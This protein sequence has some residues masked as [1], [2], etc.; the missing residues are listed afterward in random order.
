MTTALGRRYETRII[1]GRIRDLVAHAAFNGL[2]ANERV[3]G[4][5]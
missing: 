1:S 4:Y 3:R 2:E 5:P